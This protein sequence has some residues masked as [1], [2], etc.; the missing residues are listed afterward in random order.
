V[1]NVVTA[2]RIQARPSR[3]FIRLDTIRRYCKTD[4]DLTLFIVLEE[5]AEGCYRRL[6]IH[7][8]QEHPRPCGV[9]SDKPHDGERRPKPHVALNLRDTWGGKNTP[10]CCDTKPRI[11]L[12]ETKVLLW[13]AEA[14]AYAKLEDRTA[15]Y[16]P[17]AS[18]RLTSARSIALLEC[19]L[20]GEHLCWRGTSRIDHTAVCASS[21]IQIAS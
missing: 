1:M 9:R 19:H 21:E 14:P 16:P 7:G 13:E 12:T 15:L 20:E 18:L 8:S 17:V 3:V 2:A 5:L 10:K 4:L 6:E 11:L